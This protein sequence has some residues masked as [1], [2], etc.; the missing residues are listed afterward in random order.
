MYS[1]CVENKRVCVAVSK[2]RWVKDEAVAGNIVVW[3]FMW[4]Q[5]TKAGG[6]KFYT[7]S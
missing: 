2:L 4:Q 6:V 3:M 7:T 1:F 5:R